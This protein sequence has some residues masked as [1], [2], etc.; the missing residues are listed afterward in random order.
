MRASGVA[1]VFPLPWVV[2]VTGVQQ[3]RVARMDTVL[4]VLLVEDDDTIRAVVREAFADEGWTVREAAHGGAALD[5]LTDWRPDVIVLDLLMPV[6]DGYTFRIHQRAVGRVTDVPLLVLSSSRRA[7]EARA[8]LGATAVLIKPFDLDD[9]VT[10]VR[11]LTTP[12][13]ENGTGRSAA[14]RAS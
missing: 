8:A 1:V 5:I 7:P 14:A 4:R 3:G 2:T 9:L 13:P 6:M 12:P 10:T 11:R